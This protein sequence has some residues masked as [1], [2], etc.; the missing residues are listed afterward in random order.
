VQA[1]WDGHSCRRQKSRGL[2]PPG[3]GH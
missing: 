1:E 3:L 2:D